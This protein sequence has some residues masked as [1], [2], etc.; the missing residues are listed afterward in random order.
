MNESHTRVS[1][2]TSECSAPVEL[3]ELKAKGRWSEQSCG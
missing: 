3:T 1:G 2:T